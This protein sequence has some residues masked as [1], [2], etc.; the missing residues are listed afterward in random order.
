MQGT[1]WDDLRYFL[2][3]SQRGS[4]SGAAQFL[5][6]NHSTV[7]RH[8]TSLE[9]RLGV[10]LFERLTSGYVITQAGEELSNELRGVNDQ[11]EAAQRQLSGRDLALSGVIRVT[12]TDT[13]VTGLLM[14]VLAEFRA[15][16]SA[17][18][19]QVVVN[20][21]FLNLTRREADVA[22]RPSNRVPDNLV[23]RRVGRVRTAPYAA[24][25][26]LRKNSRK[27]KLEEYDWV[28]PD[29]GLSHLSQAKWVREHVPEERI[30]IRLDSLVGMVEAVRD[31]MGV[32]LLLC[33]LAAD[34]EDLLPL[35]EPIDDLDTDLWLLL[36]PD[37]RQTA[38]IKAFTNFLYDKL[39]RSGKIVPV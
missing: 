30:A 10:R 16:H 22:I 36:H 13:L 25:A 19:L 18:Q 29:E 4:V 21:S 9:K 38:R 15:L 11:I 39:S 35:A 23:G 5:K 37:V 33:L 8:L 26:Y 24:R 1:D 6:V 14:P 2:A 27:K 3:V 28:A 12:S 17:I 32:G 31:G 34:E 20:N 7:L